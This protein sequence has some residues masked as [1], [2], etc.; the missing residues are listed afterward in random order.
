[1]TMQLDQALK[2]AHEAP[3]EKDEAEDHEKNQS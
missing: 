2:Q 3:P 1:M